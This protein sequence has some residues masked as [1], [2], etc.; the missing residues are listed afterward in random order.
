MDKQ[1]INA[2]SDSMIN[3]A[4]AELGLASEYVNSHTSVEW[5]ENGDVTISVIVEDDNGM[6]VTKEMTLKQLNG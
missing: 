3:E 5:D 4:A 2:Y 6:T 1:V